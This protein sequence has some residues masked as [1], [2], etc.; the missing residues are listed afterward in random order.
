M[1]EK[2]EDTFRH[3]QR[4]FELIKELESA[5]SLSVAKYLE[6]LECACLAIE[7]N[8]LSSAEIERVKLA[9]HDPVRHE[10]LLGKSASETLDAEE[11]SELAKLTQL[12]MALVKAKMSEL[13]LEETKSSLFEKL[14]SIESTFIIVE[15]RMR[16][17][18]GE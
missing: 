2:P 11:S 6:A 1:V 12:I 17:I 15:D 14:L 4:L 13:S 8:L 10:L 9:L 16:E 5:G 18:D 7:I 3:K